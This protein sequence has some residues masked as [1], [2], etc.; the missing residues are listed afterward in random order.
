MTRTV[1]DGSWY[2]IEQVEA[3]WSAVDGI[4]LVSWKGEP[5]DSHD[6]PSI[7]EQQIYMTFLDTN[8]DDA[9]PA[10]PR[11]WCPTH[12]RARTTGSP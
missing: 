7:S 8:G 1:V 6:I 12:P 5:L 10:V 11:S 9:E 2:D 3:A 4:Y